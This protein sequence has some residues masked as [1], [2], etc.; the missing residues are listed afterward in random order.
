[1][2]AAPM[3]AITMPA[4][5]RAV[6]GSRR[7]RHESAALKI[8]D[9]DT[10]TL[11]AATEVSRT[12]AIQVAKWRASAAPAAI[13]IHRCRASIAW[14]SRLGAPRKSGARMSVAIVT[15][16]AAMALAGAEASRM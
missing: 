3:I 6:G 1:M 11:D 16:Q 9:I 12:D 10:R 5:C 13:A 7:K 14:N 8:G 4:P 15:R 2:M